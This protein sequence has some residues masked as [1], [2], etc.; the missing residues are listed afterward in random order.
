MLPV[1]VQLTHDDQPDFSLGEQIIASTLVEAGT[2]GIEAPTWNRGDQL[3]E[4][5]HREENLYWSTRQRVVTPVIVLDQFE[6]IFTLGYQTPERRRRSRD[7]I[8][9]LADLIENRLP[10]RT[11][12][13]LEAD[14]K[15]VLG[16][17]F[18]S[19]E[20]PIKV[21]LCLREDFL[22]DLEA[23]TKRMPSLRR[24]RLRLSS[25]TR[26][27][28][29]R[30]IDSPYVQHLMAPDVLNELLDFVSQPEAHNDG[31]P[32]K[33]TLPPGF[34]DERPVD[35]ALMSIFCY[36]LNEQRIAQKQAQVTT[37]LLRR[38]KHGILAGFYD[39]AIT[40]I[41]ES[42]AN[43]VERE[44]VSPGGYRDSRGLDGAI[45][46]PGVTKE[47]LDLLVERRL[48]RYTTRGGGPQRVEISHDV[49][50]ESVKQS[51]D[52]RLHSQ[53]VAKARKHRVRRALLASLVSVLLLG[54][55]GGLSYCYLFV[56]EHVEYYANYTSVWG[57]PVGIGE[58][59]QEQVSH[60]PVSLMI[61]RQGIKGRVLS[62]TAVNYERNPTT[63]HH[64]E[65]LLP[66]MD[67]PRR[68]TPVK[69][70]YHYA[71]D[72]LIRED[73]IDQEG[74]VVWA[75]QYLEP[76]A[77]DIGSVVGRYEISAGLP[78][79][80]YGVSVSVKFDDSGYPLQ[81]SYHDWRGR[82]V[83]GRFSAYG[84]RFVH[85]ELGRVV[86]A[87]SLDEFGNPIND[88]DG[89]CEYRNGKFDRFGNI[90][91]HYLYDAEGRA[92]HAKSGFFFYARE[93]DE[94]GNVIAV[95][96]FGVDGGAVHISGGYHRSENELNEHGQ[97]VAQRY[98]GADG[99]QVH[100]GSGCYGYRLEYGEVGLAVRTSCLGADGN[101]SLNGG[102]Y[103]T[104]ENG[105]DEW[106]GVREVKY[107]DVEGGSAWAKWG[108]SGIRYSRDS[109]GLAVSTEF[110]TARPDGGGDCAGQGYCAYSSEYDESSGQLVAVR[111]FANGRG[112]PCRSGYTREEMAYD[113]LGRLV[114]S[115]YFDASG[116]PT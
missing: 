104:V 42:T 45:T 99:V 95:S 92:T 84:Q 103:A 8:A 100:D 57:Q 90:G 73:A 64:I 91:N 58:L 39:R 82:P 44:L 10:A 19:G 80:N 15:N 89:N 75:L 27:Q 94:Y 66:G 113:S 60:R 65:P 85:D 24:S 52:L 26:R 9:E 107:L 111:C 34:D 114:E 25:M 56:W 78:I 67:L 115:R 20:V 35:P 49:L 32:R 16:A 112:V 71:G 86:R 97:I 40:G 79:S 48:L 17:G 29:R 76:V 69:W 37:E 108:G 28:A 93:Y 53:S 22:A 31:N 105:Y 43:F 74:N 59:T 5:F 41:S 13:K 61:T 106:G 70:T 38:N 116:K 33:G 50:L 83:V 81:I 2:R 54:V 77:D 101:V 7:F 87:M 72:R 109:R 110:S 55:V 6:E 63:I 23:F 68:K 36:E 21:V 98:Y 1:Y 3:W 47:A 30:V 18:V 51:R 88:S 12:S 11:R 14:G 96:Y 102:G 62:M 46:H 4:H